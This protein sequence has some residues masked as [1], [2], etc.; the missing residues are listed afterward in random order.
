MVGADVR[1]LFKTMLCCLFI[2]VL[3]FFHAT[4]QYNKSSEGRVYESEML[5]S[6]R[7]SVERATVFVHAFTALPIQRPSHQAI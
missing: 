7:S 6:Y 4:N 2:W 1:R 5:G 3:L